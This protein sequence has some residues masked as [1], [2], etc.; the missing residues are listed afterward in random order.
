MRAIAAMPSSVKLTS[1]PSVASSALYCA[2]S[3][4]LVSDRIAMKS[5]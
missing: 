3:D 2:G 1:A 5:S 4:A